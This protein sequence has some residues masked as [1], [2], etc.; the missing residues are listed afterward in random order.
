VT[1][2]RERCRR[3][4]K[5]SSQNSGNYEETHDLSSITERFA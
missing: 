5:G 1:V 4:G 2:L 3:H